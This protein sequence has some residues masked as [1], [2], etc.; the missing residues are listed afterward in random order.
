MALVTKVMNLKQ[1]Q[2][3]EQ[4][5]MAFHDEL[6][7][8]AGQS[9][10]SSNLAGVLLSSLSTLFGRTVG[11]IST[12]AY[13]MVSIADNQNSDAIAS[14]VRGGAIAF[15]RLGDLLRNGNYINVEFQFVK[16]D[17]WSN[18]STPDHTYMSGN[19]HDP[20]SAYIIQQVQQS[21]GSW[22]SYTS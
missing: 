16:L 17:Y 8:G 9:T 13:E 18:A 4:S 1:V 2:D 19:V 14:Y 21:N 12:V 15:E 3:A 20:T 7:Y 5:H 10:V 6:Q 22:V 11:T